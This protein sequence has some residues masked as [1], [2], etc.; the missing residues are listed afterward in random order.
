[1]NR[2]RVSPD[3][4]S[5]ATLSQPDYEALQDELERWK[6][7]CTDAQLMR[8]AYS[9]ENDQLRELV[10]NERE[11]CAKIA[12]REVWVRSGGVAARNVAKAIRTGK[13]KVSDAMMEGFTS[14]ETD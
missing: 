3:Y 14:H 7:W 4:K 12:E 1:M 6:T 13:T 5:V 10:A 8:D 11:A 2:Q 9:R